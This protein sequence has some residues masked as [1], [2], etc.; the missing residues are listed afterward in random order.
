MA[1]HVCEEYPNNGTPATRHTGN[2]SNA[3][4]AYVTTAYSTIPSRRRETS[5]AIV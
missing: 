5:P 2:R 4:D 1:I 3:A